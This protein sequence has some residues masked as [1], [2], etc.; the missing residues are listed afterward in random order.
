[1]DRKRKCGHIENTQEELQEHKLSHEVYCSNFSGIEELWSWILIGNTA[2]NLFA[3]LV[4]FCF[5]RNRS[6]TNKCG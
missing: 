5:S 4:T 3:L 6:R 1:M 2:V